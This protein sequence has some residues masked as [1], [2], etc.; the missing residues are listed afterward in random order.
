MLNL[1]NHAHD[2]IRDKL[3]KSMHNM[4]E[5]EEYIEKTED[6]QMGMMVEIVREYGNEIHNIIKTLKD[7]HTGDEK[8]ADAEMIFSTVHRA[9]GME[10]DVVYLVNDFITEDKLEK[11]KKSADEGKEAMN[12]AKLNEEINLLYVAVTRAKNT[13]HIYESL[14]P[15]NVPASPHIQIEK[16]KPEANN[17]TKP[18]SKTIKDI[19]PKSKAYSVAEKRE[20]NKDAYQPWTPQLDDE[21]KQMV[22]KGTSITK[23]AGHFG[24]TKGAIH[25]RIKKLDYYG[26]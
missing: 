22:D 7:L 11:Q 6:A 4:D 15:K 3:I 20:S 2:R 26:E 18:G 23:M 19:T 1:Y 9:K 21:L 13:L 25:S 8:R 12:I 16:A 14:V 10:Y 17:T 24:R 5:L